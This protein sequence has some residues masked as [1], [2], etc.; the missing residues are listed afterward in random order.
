M[1]RFCR[2]KKPLALNSPLT[3][4]LILTV[5]NNVLQGWPG[6][7]LGIRIRRIFDHACSNLYP[8]IYLIAILR[9]AGA[10]VAKR[11][12][13]PRLEDRARDAGNSQRCVTKRPLREEVMQ[14]ARTRAV[15]VI[16]VQALDRWGGS[17]PHLILT[18]AEQDA[19]GVAFVMRG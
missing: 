18:M 11:R 9:P 3:N 13:S 7:G 4:H 6:P 17:V 10:D 2:L 15:D 12:E 8:R 14:M 19:L 5:E 1:L 16:L